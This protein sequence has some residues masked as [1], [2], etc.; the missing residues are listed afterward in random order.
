MSMRRAFLIVA[1]GLLAGLPGSAWG[2]AYPTRAIEIVVPYAPGGGTDIMVR[3]IVKVIEEQKLIAV[4]LTVNNKVGGSGVVGKSYAI[5]RPADGYT[6]VAVDAGNWQQELQG[7]ATW[8][9]RKDFTYIARMVTD[10]NLLIVRKESPHQTLEGF[11]AAAR[12]K[13]KGG[14]SVGGTNVGQVDHIANINLNKAAKVDLTY[15]PF[16]S[17]GEVMTNLLGGHVEAAWANPNECIGQL[18]AG[19]VRALAVADEERL[20]GLPKIA[21]MKELGVAMVSNQWRAVGGPGNL[22]KPVVDFWVNVLDKVRQTDAWKKGFL[23]KSVLE[24]GWLIG[25]AF[26]QSA[27]REMEVD[28]GVFAELGML[29]K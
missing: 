1:L 11:L 26:L 17:G 18:E 19:Q 27:D 6:L 12:A 14:L 21:T 2:Q 23:E 25:D 3:Q 29:K 13:G 16:K 4:P 10:V 5:N 9:Y 15:V 24:D 28:K 8:N 20:K 22:P 7:N